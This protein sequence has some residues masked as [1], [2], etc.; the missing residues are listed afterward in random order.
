MSISITCEMR[1]K[2]FSASNETLVM[3]VLEIR[4]R[5]KVSVLSILSS[6]ALLSFWAKCSSGIIPSSD[7]MVI[8]FLTTSPRPSAK[9][10]IGSKRGRGTRATKHISATFIES[11]RANNLSISLAQYRAFSNFDDLV[12]A[13]ASLDETNLNAEK[14]NNMTTLLPT[15]SELNQLKQLNG[16]VE[17]LGRAELFFLAVAN[18]KLFREKVH[19]FC[20]LLQFDEQMKTLHTNLITLETACTEIISSKIFFFVCKK[21]LNIGNLMN[22]QSATGI[23]LNSLIKIAKK[24]GRDGK[25][26]VID[27]L[28][29]TADNCDAMSFKHDMPTLRDCTRLDLDEMK[30]SLREI[31]SGMKSIDSTIEAEQSQIASTDENERP[32]HSVDFLSKIIPF[33]QRAA[34][35]LKTMNDLIA[36]VTSKVEELKRFFAEEQSSTSA[37][38]FE[39]LLEFSSIVETSKEAYHRKQRALRRRDSMQRPRTANI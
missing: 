12:T 35:E 39:Q 38:I 19:S 11:K 16:H 29:S 4:D 1:S 21:L 9:T 18:M 32:K 26:S 27:H 28:I 10:A 22:D 15:T 5:S 30:L 34:N 13:V 20:Y 37:S 31:E 3:G 25:S 2:Q 23:T 36:R 24:K 7:R 17:G 8:A 33:Q 14:V 6:S